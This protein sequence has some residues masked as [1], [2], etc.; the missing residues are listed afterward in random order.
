MEY[1]K[2]LYP[3]LIIKLDSNRYRHGYEYV[4]N[5]VFENNSS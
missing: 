4:I 3:K 1:L 2:G 5:L